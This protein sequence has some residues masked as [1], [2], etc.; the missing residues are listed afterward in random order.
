MIL[1]G[2]VVIC[3]SSGGIPGGYLSSSVPSRILTS[4]NFARMINSLKFLPK[5]FTTLKTPFTNFLP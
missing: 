2:E 3:I 4:T 5:D 1:F